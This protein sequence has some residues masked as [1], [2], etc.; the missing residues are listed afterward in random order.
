MTSQT[1]FIYCFKGVIKDEKNAIITS[2]NPLYYNGQVSAF[3]FHCNSKM[4]KIKG[5]DHG[6]NRIYYVNFFGE[7][8]SQ[9]CYSK[10]SKNQHLSEQVKIPRE[11]FTP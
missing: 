6:R 8:Y 11:L 4:C 9:K 10:K 3:N 7:Y 5:G 2:R 1:S